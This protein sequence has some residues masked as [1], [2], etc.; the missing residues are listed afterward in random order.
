MHLVGGLEGRMC[1]SSYHKRP[2]LTRPGSLPDVFRKLRIHRNLTK[3]ALAEKFSVSES[4]IV[5]VENGSKFP[6]LRYCL[7]CAELYGANPGWVKTKW[8]KEAVNR[9]TER[10]LRRLNLD[11]QGGGG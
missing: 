3:R 6:S 4:Y 7:K 9:F 8:S 5:A 1:S 2:V 11:P 10:L